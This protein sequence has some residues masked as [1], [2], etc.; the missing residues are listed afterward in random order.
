MGRVQFVRIAVS[1]TLQ[2]NVSKEADRVFMAERREESAR[3]ARSDRPAMKT[4]RILISEPK[5]AC[6][7]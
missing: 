7:A 6:T 5:S 3:N 1:V 4:D 2:V